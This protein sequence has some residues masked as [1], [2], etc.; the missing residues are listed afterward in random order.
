VSREHEQAELQSQLLQVLG[1]FKPGGSAAV[2]EHSGEDAEFVA[3]HERA[4][5]DLVLNTLYGFLLTT[6]ISVPDKTGCTAEEAK[7][8]WPQ[9]MARAWDAFEGHAVWAE[10]V[11]VTARRG[12]DGAAA[13]F[14]RKPESYQRAFLRVLDPSFLDGFGYWLPMIMSCA[15]AEYAV[16]R[17][18]V[19]YA[20]H[21][22]DIREAGLALLSSETTPDSDLDAARSLLV[23]LATHASRPNF[24]DSQWCDLFQHAPE[25]PEADRIL[26]FRKAV[27]AVKQAMAG[28]DPLMASNGVSPICFSMGG[29]RETIRRLYPDVIAV[30]EKAAAMN[31]DV[32]FGQSKGARI[33]LQPEEIQIEDLE[34]VLGGIAADSSRHLVMRHEIHCLYLEHWDKV[35]STMPPEQGRAAMNA[36]LAAG[37]V[38]NGPEGPVGVLHLTEVQFDAALSPGNKRHLVCWP[39]GQQLKALVEVVQRLFGERW[40]YLTTPIR[41]KLGDWLHGLAWEVKDRTFIALEEHGISSFRQAASEAGRLDFHWRFPLATHAHVVCF[42]KFGNHTYISIGPGPEEL[43]AARATLALGIEPN[44]PTRH[45]PHLL[46]MMSAVSV[47]C[48]LVPS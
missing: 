40:A 10:L 18:A 43:V 32:R 3:V 20:L 23:A 25:I 41:T 15:I 33:D 36:M 37:E 38:R 30:D 4:H 14:Q 11:T 31:D 44:T 42:G 46:R 26:L 19:G 21:A 17:A 2:F 45:T 16:D 22:V 13:S 28:L 7:T 29:M 27:C 24:E 8:I 12:V 48:K 35:C 6:F 47:T 9:L 1:Y 39:S 5:R 34:E